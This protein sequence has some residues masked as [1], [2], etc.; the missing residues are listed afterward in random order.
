MTKP[1]ERQLA[2]DL[3]RSG[4]PHKRIASMIGVSPS[5]V[6]G[7]TKD[8]PLTVEQ[9]RFNMRGPSGPQNPE[10][11]RRRVASWVAKCRAARLA[12]QE[13]G[14]RAALEGDALHQ[15]GCMLYWA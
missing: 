10:V 8:I 9:E 11:V 14:R 5:S 15:A 1:A 3:R 7:W 12:W 6:H 13:E 2:R 4:M